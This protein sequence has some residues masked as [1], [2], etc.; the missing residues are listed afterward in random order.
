MYCI[1]WKLSLGFTFLDIQFIKVSAYYI[2][3]PYIIYMFTAKAPVL[4]HV[5]WVVGGR[6]GEKT[7]VTWPLTQTDGNQGYC[8]AGPALQTLGQ[9]CN[10]IPPTS[11]VCCDRRWAWL[12]ANDMC[13]SDWHGDWQLYRSRGVCWRYVEGVTGSANQGRLCNTKKIGHS[14]HMCTDMWRTNAAHNYCGQLYIISSI[15]PGGTITFMNPIY[16]KLPFAD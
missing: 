1:C 16:K 11:R 5:G 6:G 9:Q 4:W 10:N 3:L 12:V 8:I 15:P 2:I 13:H 14:V 7:P